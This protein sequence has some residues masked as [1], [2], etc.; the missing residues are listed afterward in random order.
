LGAGTQTYPIEFDSTALNP[1]LCPSTIACVDDRLYFG[2]MAENKAGQGKVW[3]RIK[4]C[5]ACESERRLTSGS[6]DCSLR[7]HGQGSAAFMLKDLKTG[8][9][10]LTILYLAWVLGEVHARL[11]PALTNGVEPILTCNLGVPVDHIDARSPLHQTYQR[12]ARG[13]WRLRGNIE[14]GVSA[15][16]ALGWSSGLRSISMGDDCPVELCPETSAAVVSQLSASSPMPQGMYALVDIGAWTTDISVFRLT[17]VAMATEGVRTTAFYEAETHRMAAGRIDQLAADLVQS[18]ATALKAVARIPAQSDDIQEV[19]RTMREANGASDSADGTDSHPL[20]RALDFM[21][22]VVAGEV[23][24]SFEAGAERAKRK[25]SQLSLPDWKRLT[26]LLLGGGS[27]EPCFEAAL[28]K[29]ASAPML[30]KLSRDERLEM[31][32]SP[33]AAARSR[34]LQVAAGLAIPAALWPKRFLPSA[35][36]RIPTTPTVARVRL[37]R[38]ELYPK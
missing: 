3:R 33:A 29:S 28:K 11:P 37:D 34:R 5:S 36:E 31:A 7:H 15:S 30:R 38:D 13:A 4:V 17:D 12:I 19:C 14:Q 25:E 35:V 22:L 9:I 1:F 18:N 8:P 23:K 32:E 26:V 10:E 24:S 21:R 16:K 6:C 20:V 2:A 27:E